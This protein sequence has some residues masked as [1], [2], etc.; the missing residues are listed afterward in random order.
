[1]Q[2]VGCAVVPAAFGRAET[3]EMEEMTKRRSSE[4]LVDETEKQNGHR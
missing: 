1:M 3:K 4:F 2:K